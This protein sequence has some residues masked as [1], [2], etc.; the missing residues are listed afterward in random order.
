M[1]YNDN[2]KIYNC[3]CCNKLTFEF[4]PGGTFYICPNCYYEDD[5]WAYFS[6]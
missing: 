3:P 4:N 1:I 6:S 5:D 2:A